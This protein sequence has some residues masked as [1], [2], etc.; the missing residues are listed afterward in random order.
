MKIESLLIHGGVDGDEST[1][2]V[3]VPVY[4]SSTFKQPEFGVT[5]GYEYARTG[6]PTREALEKLIT[7]LEHGYAGFAFASGLA[8]INAV[9]S[10]FN[11]GDK[12]II[13]NNVYGGTFRIL[14]KVFKNFNINYKIVDTSNLEEVSNSISEDIKAIYIETPTN[15]LMDITDI[16]EISKIAKEKN[17][18]TIVD[19]TFLTPYLQ[20]PITLGA[21]IV[22][23]SATKYLGGHSDVVAGLVV[24]NS[25]ELADKIGFLQN[26]IGGVLPPFDSYL[27]IRGIK[28]LAVRMDR[29]NENAKKIAEYLKS[30]HEVVK[31]YYPG[32]AEHPGHDIQAKQARGFGGILSFVLKEDYDYKKFLGSFDLI[33]FGESLGGVESLICHPASM[34][35]GAIPYEI[36]QK[37]GIVDTL[38]R[39]SVGIENADDILEDIS[40]AFDRS[41]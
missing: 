14:D 1:G 32:F 35:H 31:V 10:L 8:A 12:I 3:N 39:I 17:I 38:I 36:R 7:D 4:L 37:V 30:R 16:K 6:N 26:S 29:H 20:T 40:K 22:I 9:L 13:S 41:K 28:T 21:D 15:P 5:K 18:L 2:A 33:T 24:T 11:A 27:L 25:K 23:H 19:N 34:T